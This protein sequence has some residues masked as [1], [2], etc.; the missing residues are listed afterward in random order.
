M[1]I[2]YYRKTLPKSAEVRTAAAAAAAPGSKKF[3]LY[4]F[5]LWAGRKKCAASTST[6][7]TTDILLLYK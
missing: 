6:T 1:L 5:I 7:N 2:K 3:Q 4:D